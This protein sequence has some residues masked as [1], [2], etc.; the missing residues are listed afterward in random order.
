MVYEQPKNKGLAPR[1][2]RAASNQFFAMPQPQL[3]ASQ[4]Q[5]AASQPLLAASQPQLAAS[6]QFFAMPHPQLAA[7]NQFFAMPQPQVV[8]SNVTFLGHPHETDGR[9]S[10]R[11]PVSSR[12]TR[13]C[14]G[15]S[16]ER[17]V[18]LSQ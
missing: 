14:R 5:L 2:N 17:P 11:T 6:N 8:G 4:P 10:L 1:V 18:S 3:A 15:G 13:H 7:S 16:V 12:S 9:L